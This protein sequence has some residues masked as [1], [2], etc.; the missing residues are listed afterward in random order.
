MIMRRKIVIFKIII[1][2]SID[3]A[4]SI[5]R[6]WFIIGNTH[7]TIGHPMNAYIYESTTKFEV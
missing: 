2:L 1:Q 6:E 4:I 5:V 3:L 7:R